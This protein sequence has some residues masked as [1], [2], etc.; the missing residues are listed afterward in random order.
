MRSTQLSYNGGSALGGATHRSPGWDHN[1]IDLPFGVQSVSRQSAAL[2]RL[3]EGGQAAAVTARWPAQRSA[4]WR[5]SSTT[6]L[7]LPSTPPP[8]RTPPPTPPGRRSPPPRARLLPRAAPGGRLRCRRRP[9]RRARRK[10]ATTPHPNLLPRN[11]SDGLRVVAVRRGQGRVHTHDPH[12]IFPGK[13]D[14]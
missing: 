2:A 13:S 7:S 6:R 14:V 3:T 8:P 11:I 5:A 9:P 1:V 12:N 10:H 4:A